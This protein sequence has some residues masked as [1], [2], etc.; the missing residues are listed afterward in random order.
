[1]VSAT[2]EVKSVVTYHTRM[3]E[4]LLQRL[5]TLDKLMLS[6]NSVE[7]GTICEQWFRSLLQDVLPLR[8]GLGWGHVSW[9]DEALE[10]TSPLDVII[11]DRH[12][13][14][15]HFIEGSFVVVPPETLL[16]VVEVKAVVR[17]GS[18]N[19]VKKACTQLDK[20]RRRLASRLPD[21][22]GRGVE[23]PGF[24]LAFSP[25]DLTLPRGLA[26]KAPGGRAWF[27]ERGQGLRAS[28][29]RSGVAEVRATWLRLLVLAAARY[30]VRRG[31]EQ[32]RRRCNESARLA[33]DGR[34][35]R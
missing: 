22:W 26:G 3:A 10:A 7:K 12:N 15:P 21:D 18:R 17:E 23:F 31:A 28:L 25:L 11:Y 24:V 9:G 14:S 2:P 20:L 33:E 8:F 6:D 16:A 27:R 32:G 30:A 19:L 34:I 1:M 4:Q 13:H 35:R 5:L 29:G